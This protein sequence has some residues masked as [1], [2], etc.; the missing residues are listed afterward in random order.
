MS[1]GSSFFVDLRFFVVNRALGLSLSQRRLTGDGSPYPDAGDFN[2][3]GRAVSPEAAASAVAFLNVDRRVREQ[4]CS[5]YFGGQS[6]AVA[7]LLTS[8]SHP[9]ARKGRVGQARSFSRC[10]WRTGCRCAPSR[11]SCRGGLRSPAR[12]SA[13]VRAG[14]PLRRG[15][16]GCAD[17]RFPGSAPAVPGGGR[18]REWRGCRR[19]SQISY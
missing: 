13:C 15:R 6:G 2:A 8:R 7:M 5:R 19:R 17:P 1:D 18:H 16:T 10:S 9:R 3:Y 14:A 4:G 11:T 12:R